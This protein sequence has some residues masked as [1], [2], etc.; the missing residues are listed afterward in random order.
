M[1]IQMVR[2]ESLK[3]SS[4]KDGCVSDVTDDDVYMKRSIGLLGG[5]GLVLGTII[6]VCVC[7]C[8]SE[9]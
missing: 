5:I 1:V 8:V 6:G 9:C 3:T 4:S 2:T 7:Q